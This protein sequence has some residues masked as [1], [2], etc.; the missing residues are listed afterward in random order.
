MY[1]NMMHTMQRPRPLWEWYAVSSVSVSIFEG[2]L[3]GLLLLPLNAYCNTL[4][5]T[6]SR[7]MLWV[8]PK[9]FV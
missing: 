4:S 3:G 6:R 8:K 2:E 9:A 5:T 7:L 1:V